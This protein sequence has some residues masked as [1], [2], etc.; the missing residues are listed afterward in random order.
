MAP[1]EL[2]VL[3]HAGL[4][5]DMVATRD[6]EVGEEV[7][8]NYGKHSERNVSIKYGYG[9]LTGSFSSQATTGRSNGIS[10]SP[11]GSPTR[12]IRVISLHL[13]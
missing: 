12:R 5:M 10:T 13:Y 1:R 7:Y 11:G 4:M 2:A 6:I 3:D 9:S 8:L